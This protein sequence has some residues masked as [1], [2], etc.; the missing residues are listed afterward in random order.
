[1]AD[2]LTKLSPF[3]PSKKKKPKKT[4]SVKNTVASAVQKSRKELPE[5]LQS[6]AEILRNVSVLS[7]IHI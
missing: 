4:A 7:L 6:L 1:M 5:Y 3:G 2:H